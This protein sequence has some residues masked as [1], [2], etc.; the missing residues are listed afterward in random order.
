[1]LCGSKTLLFG[2]NNAQ[3]EATILSMNENAGSDPDTSIKMLDILFYAY[4]GD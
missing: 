2:A 4:L 1:M 3:R